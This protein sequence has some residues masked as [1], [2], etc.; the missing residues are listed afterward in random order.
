M[1]AP[2]LLAVPNFTEGRDGATIAA[3]TDAMEAPGG[4][5]LLDLHS[6]PDHNR[7]VF[8]LAGRPLELVHALLAGA[9]VA[10]ERIDILAGAPGAH[11]HVGALDVAPIVHRSL[12]HRGAACA[13]ALTFADRLAVELGLPVFLY[14]ALAG[15]RTRADLRRGGPAGLAERM[16]SGEQRPDFGPTRP[17]PGAGATLVCAREPL[18]AFN[19]ELAAPADLELAQRIAAL[20][21][22]GGAEGLPGLRA[23]GLVLQSRGVV[24]VSVNVEQPLELPLGDVVA[25][26]RRHAPV[27]RAEIVGL[28]PAAALAN[29]PAEVPI[30]G[31]DPA[32]G[33]I[34]TVLAE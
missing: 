33:V 15:G 7:S 14:G 13:T 8:T 24:Q 28:V 20:L 29:F 3:L 4:A 26:V 6:D 17:H 19:V 1:D 16:K 18:V 34:E 5:R 21:R 9:R 31:F 27:Q 30:A 22:E 23:I 25:A 11:P 32:S 12:A 10:I 2:T